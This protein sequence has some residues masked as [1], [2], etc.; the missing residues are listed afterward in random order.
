MS[1]KV[2]IGDLRYDYCGVLAND[3][4]PLGVSYLKTVMDRDVPEVESR[5]FAYPAT[6]LDALKND[7]PDVLMLSNYMWCEELS[8]YFAR[9]A[10]RIN[11]EM[12]VVFGGPNIHIEDERQKQYMRE[13]PE[14]D[15]FVLG[16]GDF[17]AAEVMKHYLDAG[18]SRKKLG[19][20]VLPSSLYRTADGEIRLEKMWDRRREIDDIPSPWL[21]GALDE[22]F[23]GRLVPMIET[24]RGCPFSCTFCVQGTR[25]YTK[26]HYFSL[27][28]IRE[29]IQ[30]IAR[31]V[32]DK[33]RQVGTLRIA[34]SNYGMFERD[35]EIS[36]Y[37]GE[38]QRQYKWPTMID[39]TT[40][41]NRPE[42]IIESLEK[43]S[44]ALVLYQAV[45]S[46]DEDVLRKIKRQNIKLEAY[47]QLQVAVRGRGLRSNSDLILAL[48]G[49]TLESHIRA[50]HK[51]VDAGVD[52]VSTFQLILLKGSEMETLASREEFAFEQRYRISPKTFGEYGGEKVFDIEHV[53]VATDTLPFEDYV[54]AR[55]YALGCAALWHDNN[56]DEV[57]KL[58]DQLGI[59][60]SEWLERMM[61]ELQAA[62]E[63]IRG[64]VENFVAET[65]GELFATPE[66]CIE[67]YSQPDNFARLLKS[68]I[69]D[70]LVR[71][72]QAIASLFVWRELCQLVLR[73][74]KEMLEERGL[75][76]AIPDFGAFWENFAY[77]QRYKH[78]DGKNETDILTPVRVT[79]TYDIKRWIE[80]GMPMQFGA[81][82]LP[83][84]E[85]FEFALSA[86]GASGLSA[87]IQMYGAELKGLIRMM[88]RIRPS[89]LTREC[90]KTSAAAFAAAAQSQTMSQAAS[91]FEQEQAR[92]Y[93]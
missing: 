63:P 17:L 37:I 26:V 20:R 36:S 66:A 78:A 59:K 44:G 1:Q 12:L 3:C 35:I 53:V 28:R 79:L 55:I 4:M 56:F 18:M 16:E 80:D 62:D 67:F 33:C 76:S 27:E 42:R 70:N 14:V 68:E 19:E 7:P 9:V 85:E 38:M 47:E 15:V 30:Y 90:R 2:Y 91:S 73:S 31:K 48:P 77:Y 74:T 39:A 43:V 69:G 86:D 32:H 60:R 22:F 34:D 81:Y 25:W 6:L 89:W 88:K 52:Q 13:H 5:L 71:K 11:P 41:K 64:F 65:K 87:A 24:N 23:D 50:I 82:R 83:D 51:L 40:G 61:A 49:E 10:K 58:T 46:L 8:H 29:E 75:T 57:L 84:P 21:T 92:L 72:Y 54:K 93:R 45:Q